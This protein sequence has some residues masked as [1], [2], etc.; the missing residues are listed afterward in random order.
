MT[1]ALVPVVLVAFALAAMGLGAVPAA[2]DS[3]SSLLGN[4]SLR[5][6]PKTTITSATLVSGT[7]TPANG[8]PAIH[9]LPAFCRV[10]ATLAPSAV[11]DVKVEVWM[12]AAGWNG[13]LQA[14][15]NGGLAGTI[16]YNALAPAIKSGYASAST[17]T[18]HVASDTTWLP[19]EDREKDYGFRAIHGMTVAAKAILRQFYGR[20]A[21]RSYFNGCSTGGGQGFGEAQLYPQDFDGILAGAPQDFPTR[22]R[23]AVISD[24]QA[25][26]NSSASNLPKNTL[27][28]I[29]TAVLSQCGGKDALADG[30]LSEDP[31]TCRFDPEGLL[32]KTGQDQATCLTAP[33]VTAVRK[34]YAGAIDPRTSELI[35]PG[36]MPG[37][38][39][40]AGP[41]TVGWQLSG[42]NGPTPFAA[43]AQFYSFGVFQNPDF[44]FH[45]MDIG[46]AV[47]FAEKKFPFLNHTSTDI[48]AFSRR[49]GKLLMYH[50]WDDPL[51]SPLNSINYYG[52]LAEATGSKRHLGPDAARTETQKAA[53]L[54]M[55]PGMGHCS[56]GPGP[57]N[58]DAIGALDQ[59]V[60]KGVAPEKII[61]S[62]LSNGAPTFSRPLCPYPQ[63]ARYTGSGDRANANNWAC[64]AQPFAFDSNFYK[65]RP[66]R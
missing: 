49:G 58:F 32:C 3:C 61:A 45:A 4:G 30:F 26:A 22:L 54:F 6:L 38:E 46:S 25:A 19:I 16:S 37:S 35:W 42:M 18:G 47:K 31:R 33:Q 48:D 62:H 21:Q 17:D 13:K 36:L 52:S 20:A 34:I 43:A 12:P 29:T 59:W 44:N 9:D 56:G 39:E 8:A 24:F 1:R 10:T 2:V 15:G 7:F 41:G 23:A 28:L 64:T 57:D 65:A 27:S 60:D 5:S 14:V 63:E 11:S 40:P 50:G 55:V 53:L 51:I 66:G